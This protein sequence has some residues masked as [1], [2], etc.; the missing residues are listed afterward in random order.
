VIDRNARIQ[1]ELIEDLLDISRMTAGAL[2]LQPQAVDLVRVAADAVD[3]VRPTAHARH[4]E[5]R[6]TANPGHLPTMADP[7]R[8]QQVLWNLLTN[9]VKFT[10]DGG[11]VAID[12]E[13][14]GTS[15]TVTVSDSGIGIDPSFM[16]RL[17][18]RFA[19]ADTRST[20]V[21]QEG[22]GLGLAI[23]REL[24]DLHGGSLVAKS[25]GPGTGA[26][27][28]VTLPLTMSIAADSRDQSGPFIERL[29]G[30]R[31]LVVDDLPDAREMVATMLEQA[32]A[33]VELA[34]SAATAAEKL[35]HHEFDA[36]VSDLAMPGRDGYALAMDIQIGKVHAKNPKMSLIALSAY[37]RGED[38]ERA[39]AA[40]FYAHLAK[41]VSPEDLVHTVGTAVGLGG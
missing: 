37:A 2:K 14:T 34:D 29:D 16:P 39:L 20:R 28:V 3:S 18:D 12:V 40:G 33:H 17:F 32:G 7:K 15:A 41:P 6:M 19:R 26:T 4:V 24:V 38:R 31:V 1:T 11:H 8:L 25:E 35:E 23:A 13:R 9:A 10:P 5:I 22:L 21:V 30:V 27:F 36:V